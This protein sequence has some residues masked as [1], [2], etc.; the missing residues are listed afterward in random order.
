MHSQLETELAK[1]RLAMFP[2]TVSYYCLGIASYHPLS[3]IL[4]IMV[5]T[6]HLAIYISK[7]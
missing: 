4:Q 7:L 2:Y 1:C 6:V 3:D 5:Y